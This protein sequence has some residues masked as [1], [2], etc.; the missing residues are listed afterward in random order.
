MIFTISEVEKGI[1]E[2]CI[3]L[4]PIFIKT[5]LFFKGDFINGT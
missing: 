1:V 5:G 4:W 3:I 2:T